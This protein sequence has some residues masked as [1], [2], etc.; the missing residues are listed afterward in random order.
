MVS[1]S[2]LLGLV[3]EI[4]CLSDTIARVVVVA[5]ARW[6]AV[7]DLDLETRHDCLVARQG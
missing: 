6:E 7:L 1:A 2:R 5:A 4:A 3:T